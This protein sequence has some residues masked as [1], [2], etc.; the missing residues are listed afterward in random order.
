MTFFVTMVLYLCNVLPV[1]LPGL[2]CYMDSNINNRNRRNGRN[3][4]CQDFE[5]V[6]HGFRKLISFVTTLA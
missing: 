6:V 5:V 4:T 1:C 2:H 3:I